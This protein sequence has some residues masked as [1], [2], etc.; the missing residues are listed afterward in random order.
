VAYACPL[1][2]RGEHARRVTAISNAL[3]Q[4]LSDF[5]DSRK[6]LSKVMMSLCSAGK[7]VSAVA[8]ARNP[9]SRSALCA[10]SGRLRNEY[11]ISARAA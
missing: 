9:R 5:F 11:R 10:A 6:R 2:E 7:I 1:A 8:G 4:D 3:A